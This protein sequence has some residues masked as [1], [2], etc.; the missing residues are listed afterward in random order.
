MMAM[1]NKAV[2]AVLLCAIFVLSFVVTMAYAQAAPTVPEF[3]LKLVDHP[4]DVAPTYSI[5]PYTGKNVTTQAGYHVE[6]QTIDVTIK[7]QPFTSQRDANG[8]YTRLYYNFRF[9]GHYADNWTYSP[10]FSTPA[11]KYYPYYAAS[12]SDYT[13]VSFILGSFEFGNVPE[14]G[15]V[16][17]QVEALIGSD[18]QI[19]GSY[20]PWG[21]GYYF[22]FSGESSGWSNTQIITITS[23]P[24][25][26]PIQSQSPP[27]SLSTTSILTPSLSIPEF[28]SWII[29]PASLI[30]IALMFAANKRKSLH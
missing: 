14:G 6:N 10:T 9:K 4:Y 11:L 20:T 22:E 8:N 15:M 5:D 19:L 13:V 26:T 16:D 30:V 7:N 23:T 2:K 29:L 28:P 25:Q 17:F 1:E 12:T 18:N 24:P 3:T 21:Q 27:P